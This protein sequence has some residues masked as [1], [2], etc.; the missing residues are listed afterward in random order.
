MARGDKA[1]LRL[2]V[3]LGLATWVAYGFAL[4]T[5][6][7]VCILAVL[8]LCKPGPPLPLLKAVILAAVMG[9][10]VAAGVLMVPLL[11]HEAVTGLVVTASL[12]FLL[13]YVGRLRANPLITVLVLAFTLVPVAGVSEQ[14]VIGV[15]SVTFAVGVLVG[16]FVSA[17][18]AAIFPD[19]PAAGPPARR[20]P[21]DRSEARWIAL[22]GMLIV[23]PVFV[24]ALTDPSFYLAAIMK[25]VALGQQAGE[26]DARHA[27]RELVGSTLMGALVALAVW[28]G[29]SA[30]AS[31][32]MLSLW[33]MA[34]A[35]VCGAALFGARRT[36]YPPS[37]WSN[38]L[39]TALIFL[40]P[41]IEDSASGKSVLLGAAM[42][43][44][45]FVGVALYAWAMVWA[46]ELRKARRRPAAAGPAGLPRES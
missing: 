40:G 37:F 25:S 46:L 36:R 28:T 7:L 18:S 29:L 16:A 14:A 19:P 34:A 11:V 17:M 27:G 13:F 38:A 12:L 44:T 39:V 10:M 30:W 41:A 23:M 42:R 6:Y 31:L 43:L 26:T 8:V 21:P 15:L 45:L 32:W 4:Q 35:L 1:A 3:G 9:G 2:T 20:P 5:P 22:R 24:L 33:M